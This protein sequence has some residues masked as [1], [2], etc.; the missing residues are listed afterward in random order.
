MAIAPRGYRSGTFS[1]AQINYHAHEKELLAI[2]LGI[3]KYELF[4]RPKKFAIETNSKFV[5]HF[6]HAP[7][8]KTYP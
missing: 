5:Q 4:L 7:L 2:M 3:E 6:K 8:K 1:P